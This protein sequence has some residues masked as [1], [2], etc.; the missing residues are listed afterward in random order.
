MIREVRRCADNRWPV[1]GR[2]TNRHH[3]VLDE[4]SVLDAGIEAA[5]DQVEPRFVRAHIQ[6]HIRVGACELGQLGTEYAHGCKA[7]YQQAHASAWLVTQSSDPVEGAANARQCGSQ[8]G[9]Q[10]LAGLCRRDT[11]C[12]A[13][14]QAYTDLFLESSNRLAERRLRH[15]EPLCGLGEAPL[16]SDRQE[17]RHH[18]QFISYDS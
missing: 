13:R 10:L 1:I 15:A 17:R 5:S 7:G 6:H 8:F 12:R 4:L 16:V 9:E 2:D 11:A 3:V 14:E 18:A